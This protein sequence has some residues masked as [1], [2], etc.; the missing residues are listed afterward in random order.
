MPVFKS[1]TIELHSVHVIGNVPLCVIFQVSIIEQTETG[2][3]C[4]AV[5]TGQ[6][7]MGTATFYWLVLYLFSIFPRKK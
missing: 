1:T 2:R 4:Y 3:M 6:N 7:G 5:Q